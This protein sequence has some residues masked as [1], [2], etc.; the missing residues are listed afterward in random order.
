MSSGSQERWDGWEGKSGRSGRSGSGG[1]RGKG[2]SREGRVGEVG[3]VR[4]EGVG[5]IREL[6]VPATLLTQSRVDCNSL[7]NGF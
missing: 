2:S 6:D 4:G 5:Q 7:M 3:G 1:K